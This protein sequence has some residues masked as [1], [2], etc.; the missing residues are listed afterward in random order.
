[1]IGTKRASGIAVAAAAAVGTFTVTAGADIVIGNLDAPSGGS[2]IFGAGSISQYKAFGFTM[3]DDAY[4]LDDVVLAMTFDPGASPIISIW[5]GAAGP[6]TELI[7]LDN[8]PD[9]VGTDDFSFTPSVQFTLEAN[10]TY[11]LHVR[12]KP[13]DAPSFLWS[14]STPSTEPTGIAQSLGYIYNDN[15]STF[16]NRLQINGSLV[17][18]PGAL[19]CLGLGLLTTARRRR[20]AA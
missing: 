1:M 3:G 15:P 14:S 8:P 16:R 18:A 9:L 20:H 17:P 2:T 4:Y 6:E 19:A 10:E 11:W 7:V 13:L 5:S 12:S